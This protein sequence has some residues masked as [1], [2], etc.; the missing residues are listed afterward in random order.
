MIRAIRATTLLVLF[1]PAATSVAK[2][3]PNLELRD[4]NGY[5]QRIA[6]L[7]GSI[8]VVSFWATW[9]APCQQE[10]PRLSS[11]AQS[12]AG[13]ARF[14]AISIDSPKDR[15]K[16]QPFVSSHNITM[17]IWLGG[18]TD[19]LGR[20]DLGD[21]VP[22]TLILDDQGEIITRI[23]GEA[24]DEDVRTAVDWLLNERKGPA[25]ESLIKRY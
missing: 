11:L 2:R 15:A 10:L 5:T 25:P 21:I 20:V 12:Y 9:C 8:A 7:R 1:L 17:D 3:V 6:S 13:K 22:G 19:M 16:I 18:D 23:M 4:M 14:V 24:R